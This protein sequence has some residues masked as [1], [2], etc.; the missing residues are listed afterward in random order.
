MRIFVASIAFAVTL[1][2]LFLFENY[3][4]RPQE[5]NYAQIIQGLQNTANASKPKSLTKSNKINPPIQSKNKT[6]VS[7]SSLLTPSFNPTNTP[8]ITTRSSQPSPPTAT[9]LQTPLPLPSPTPT[10][11][12]P[13]PTPTTTTVVAPVG[14][15]QPTPIPTASHIFYTS[16][17]ITAK[18]YYCDTDDAWKTLSTKYLKSFPSQEELLKPYPSRTL[19]EA[20]K[21]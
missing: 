21:N 9:P 1:G 4:T 16:S 5:E 20:C 8:V 7:P 3:K 2:G 11:S 13:T 19:H 12:T 17:Y 15:N 6:T 14:S 10:T 18:Y